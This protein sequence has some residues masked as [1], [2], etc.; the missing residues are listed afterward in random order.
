MSNVELK[1]T[2]NVTLAMLIKRRKT[3]LEQFLK[4]AGVQSYPGLKTL[5]S[6]LG[7]QPPDL[8]TYV[9]ATDTSGPVTSQSDGIVVIEA[10]EGIPA[11][12]EQPVEEI[13]PPKKQ[14]QKK[15]HVDKVG[16]S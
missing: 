7:V 6:R 12:T 16:K 5:C 15:V 8:E 11:V 2:P 10:F 14:R 3:T 9:K 1:N 13:V 4:A